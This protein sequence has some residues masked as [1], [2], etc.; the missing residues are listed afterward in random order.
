MS[1]GA[2][3]PTSPGF[4][5]TNGIPGGSNPHANGLL[6]L[7]SSHTGLASP[8]SAAHNVGGSRP[9]T[10]SSFGG[11]SFEDV[12]RWDD[13]EIASW[14]TTSRLGSHAPTFARHDIKGSVLLDVDQAALK[15]MGISSVGD[16]VRIFAAIKALNKRCADTAAAR[17]LSTASNATYGSSTSP[18]S[19]QPSFNP[20]ESHNLHHDRD[21]MEYLESESVGNRYDD[22]RN[23]LGVGMNSGIPGSPVGNRRA[24]QTRPPPL[25]LKQSA[26]RGLP[27]YASPIS[28]LNNGQG[29]G[30]SAARGLTPGAGRG[31][32]SSRT[33]SPSSNK[34]V[35]SAG[36]G[37]IPPSSNSSISK[38]GESSANSLHRKVNS[39]GT[40]NML[41]AS[42]SSSSSS[43]PS[44]QA[45]LSGA[46]S[47]S[48]YGLNPGQGSSG[49][50]SMRPSTATG[51]GG[52]GSIHSS[53]SSGR[54]LLP[55]GFSAANSSGSPTTPS[56]SQSSTT[57]RPSTAGGS[58]SSYG[59]G[60]GAMGTSHHVSGYPPLTPITESGSYAG[61][62]VAGS[63][64]LQQQ[65]Q[66]HN[67]TSSSGYTVGRGPFAGSRPIT[68]S[69]RDWA[70]ASNNLYGTSSNSSTTTTTTTNR[71]TELSEG[72]GSSSSLSLSNTNPNNAPPL[73]L[74]DLKRRTIKFISEEDKTTRIVS[75]TDCRD[76]YDVMA[77][78]LKKFGKP[79]SGNSYNPTAGQGPT[80]DE[81]GGLETWGIFATSADGQ[82]TKALSDNELLAI[83]HAPQ[84]HDPLRERGLTL[85]RIPNQIPGDEF[86]KGAPMRTG[87]NKLEAFFGERMPVAQIGLAPP[88]SPRDDS[89]AGSVT[90]SGKKMRRASTVSIMSG[91]GVG[92]GNSSRSDSNRDSAG[93]NARASKNANVAAAARPPNSTDVTAS[94]N[95]R[96]SKI[97]NFFGHRPPSDI[98]ATNLTDYF[99]AAEPK[100]LQKTARRSIY[101]RYSTSTRS[102]RNST[103]SFAA[104]LDAP[105]LP[106]KESIDLRRSPG[107]SPS[108]NESKGWNAPVIHI[109]FDKRPEEVL[110][111]H[112]EEDDVDFIGGAQNDDRGPP[113]LPDV[114]G[115][116]SLEDWSKSLQTVG[117]PS[118]ESQNPFGYATGSSD[119]RASLSTS[120]LYS[121]KALPSIRPNMARRASGESS[122]S[123]RSLVSQIRMGL[124]SSSARDRD[125]TASLLTVDEIT[126]EVE[127]RRQSMNLSES[128]S[129]LGMG[130]SFVVVDEDGVPIGE[131]GSGT[132]RGRANSTRP[133]S[134][135][136]VRVQDDSES[137]ATDSV[138]PPA[139][140]P[141]PSLD[142]SMAADPDSPTLGTHAEAMSVAAARST[143]SRASSMIR[144]SLVDEDSDVIS[145]YSTSEGEDDSEI[146]SEVESEEE[147]QVY[148]PHP[149]GKPPIKWHKG[150]LIGAGSFGNVFLGMNAKN[151]LLMA[152]KQ[153]ELPSGDSHSDQRKKGMLEALEREIKLLKTLEH[154]KIVQYL[155]SFADGT[156]LNIFLEYVP[157][158]SIVALLRNYGAFEEPLVRN[159]VRQILE[160]LS[161]LH[162]RDIVHRDIKG[163]N[164]LVDNK[165]GIKISD[166]GISKK[167]ESDLLISARAHRPSLQGSVFWMA[168]EVVKQTSYTRKADIWSLGCLVVEMIS[169][170][171]PWADLN[172]MQALF[173]IGM[174]RKPSLPEEISSEAVDFLNKT[175]ELDHNLR[176]SAD[177]LLEHHPFITEEY[178]GT[179]VIEKRDEE[180]EL[181]EGSNGG[182]GNHTNGANVDGEERM[183]EGEATVI[184]T[185]NS[186]SGLSNLANGGPSSTATAS[187]SRLKGKS[188]T[189]SKRER[190]EKK[191]EK[192]KER[193]E[194]EKEKAREAA[195]TIEDD[196]EKEKKRAEEAKGTGSN[197]SEK[198]GGGERKETGTKLSNEEPTI[199]PLTT[200]NN[201]NKKSAEASSAPSSSSSSSS[202]QSPTV[203]S[204]TSTNLTSSNSSTNTKET[205]GSETNDT[206]QPNA[207][208]TTATKT[209]TTKEGGGGEGGRTEDE[210]VVLTNGIE[211]DGGGVPQEA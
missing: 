5:L 129:G 113:K 208:S 29:F 104:D 161:F 19:F 39:A 194:R 191:E 180:E 163:A 114:V 157:G 21:E 121:G 198:V 15:E 143:A 185:N 142:D 150:A 103:W 42:F 197:P 70:G 16:R 138:R 31:S 159:F 56:F 166:F 36:G 118:S 38:S 3:T 57:T 77:K 95:S 35:S 190:R 80:G 37:S 51:A 195:N 54:G 178:K 154:P 115:R 144:T 128:R 193:K 2:G 188:S 25:L 141:R 145:D 111:R 127:Q 187:S 87:R 101:G 179:G 52:Y 199:D 210:Q 84:P 177:E 55:S 107:H 125:D 155:D 50:G 119:S 53:S 209:K 74:E 26:S 93:S 67:H 110:G 132:Y 63:S 48:P 156:H 76:A 75:V 78:V 8:R 135:I 117:S 205:N 86:K 98:I 201:P 79:A 148:K 6:G 27:G 94:P 13:A 146:E 18:R 83:C 43:N 133:S 137:D 58:I 64:I 196:A 59:N 92:F 167:V 131:P 211:G 153:V 85:R 140:A 147:K 151:G 30:L 181:V 10:P 171:H 32:I 28:S 175:F 20:R 11:T 158:G 17:R 183:D 45:K 189:L 89:D 139:D 123:R 149:S 182:G 66:Q 24:V 173:Q 126:Q 71:R 46:G 99:P 203:R 206:L 65:Q 69:S 81:M 200:N 165:G 130:D 152:V 82:N 184:G 162:A 124:T 12:R 49:G 88:G 4:P 172:Q 60:A 97:R 102:K 90:T 40:A 169:G 41:G 7:N 174:S 136:S 33:A 61:T 72:S 105:P 106:G 23:G 44:S 68:P 116:S 134:G 91:L 14:L 47:R 207:N 186:T 176:P 109:G 112:V 204:P 202:S 164:I 62:P 168:P 122:R 73:S 22:E 100:A 108:G 160:G 1:T 192:D 34:P 120:S 9:G 96:P 170:T